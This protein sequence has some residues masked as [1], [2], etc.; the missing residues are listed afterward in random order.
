MKQYRLP[1]DE[2]KAIETEFPDPANREMVAKAMLEYKIDWVNDHMPAEPPLTADGDVSL[3][4]IRR[5]LMEEI[6]LI[7]VDEEKVGKTYGDFKIA[8]SDD[9]QRLVFGWASVARTADGQV[10]KDW[11]EDTIEP[12]EIEKAAYEYVLNFR[13]TGE[14]HNPSLRNKG[15]LV[16]SVVL[17][18]EKQAAMGIPEGY[19]DEAWWVGFYIDDD[20]AWEGIKKGEYEMFSIEG[21]GRRE[22]MEKSRKARTYAELREV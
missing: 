1:E 3:E 16:E 14:R 10:V 13:A 19:V 22:K 11:Q 6:G 9:D 4:D 2:I 21:Q 7:E 20:K 15:R 12:E 8:K 18:K 5:K 17:T